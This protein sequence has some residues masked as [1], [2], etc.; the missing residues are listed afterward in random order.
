MKSLK[1]ASARS[2]NYF[3]PIMDRPSSQTCGNNFDTGSGFS[4]LV[5]AKCG[6]QEERDLFK[7]TNQLRHDKNEHMVS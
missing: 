4:A 2:F 3:T 1:H 6:Y 5:K 7:V